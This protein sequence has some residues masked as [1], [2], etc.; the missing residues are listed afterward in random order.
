M[1][2]PTTTRITRNQNSHDDKSAGHLEN[3]GTLYIKTRLFARPEPLLIMIMIDR[4]LKTWHMVNVAA[5]FIFGSMQI[6]LW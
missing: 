4:F 5:T 1:S 6:R 3:Y 2:K